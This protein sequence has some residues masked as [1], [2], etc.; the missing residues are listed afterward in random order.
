MLVKDIDEVFAEAEKAFLKLELLE[1]KPKSKR[2]IKG[3]CK[4]SA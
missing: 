1:E 2:K 4:N 3:L